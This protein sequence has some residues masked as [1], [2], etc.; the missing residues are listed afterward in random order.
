MS[1]M[2]TGGDWDGKYTKEEENN[3]AAATSSFRNIPAASKHALEAME[4]QPAIA[5][6]NN[7]FVQ[8]S[9]F[10]AGGIACLL[11]AKIGYGRQVRLYEVEELQ[12]GERKDKWGRKV[13][14]SS[15]TSSKKQ[16][17]DMPKNWSPHNVAMRALGIGTLVACGSCALGTAATF[18]YFDV[19][20]AQEFSHKMKIVIPPKFQALQNVVRG[21]LESFK[22]GLGSLFG[23]K[24][25]S[26]KEEQEQEQEQ[27]QEK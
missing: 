20:T 17:F 18:W 6:L 14:A 1:D 12:W 8:L 27:E 15:A 13:M 10:V 16:V 3:P 2:N 5:I 24:E 21:P 11:G 7:P 22:N 19:S 25:S 26:V 23:T 4:R 9:P